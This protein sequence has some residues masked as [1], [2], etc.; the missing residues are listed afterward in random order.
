MNKNVWIIVVALGTQSFQGSLVFLTLAWYFINITDSSLIFA[1]LMAFRYIPGILLTA[2]SGLAVDRMKKIPLGLWASI[3]HVVS[4]CLLLY[5]GFIQLT[6]SGTGYWIYVGLVIFLGVSSAVFTPLE[7]TLI[8][9]LAEPG[10]L[11][12]VNSLVTGIVQI[13]SLLG[14]SSA[15]ALLL[16]GG[17]TLAMSV[18]VALAVV[19]VLC[20]V[21]L[22]F[23]VKLP[24][25]VVKSK[26]VVSAFKVTITEFK[27]QKWIFP[28]IA[29]AVFTNMSFVMIM[30]VLLPKLFTG[31][32]I[33]GAA[34]LGVCFTVIGTGTLVGAAMT[35][36]FKWINFDTAVLLYIGSG[37]AGIIGG[38][39]INSIV[40]SIALFG[41]FGLLAAPISI[42]FQTEIQNSIP[43]E[44]LG[45]AMGFLA[46]GVSAAQPLGV[47][48]GGFL[49]LALSG[50]SV[51]ALAIG[52]S[53]IAVIIGW[54]VIKQ[55]QM[56]M[57]KEIHLKLGEKTI[58]FFIDRFGRKI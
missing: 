14:M 42:I 24:A 20:Y 55:Q 2:L 53:I 54:W 1:S 37:I 6:P 18:A 33:N 46:S 47:F 34:A 51:L 27:G 56:I 28:A 35:Y 30:D 21:V 49:L 26:G 50:S 19:S 57:A 25:P 8:P 40:F 12:S 44:I 23:K 38:F 36:R 17:F 39:M 16:V 4:L 58:R 15:G 48:I 5:I 31:S 11:Q 22:L 52:L 3:W 43:T 41:V 10:K 45:S 9:M 7:R 13:T 29:A 32:E